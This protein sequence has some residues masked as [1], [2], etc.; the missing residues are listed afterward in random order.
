ML[1]AAGAY[2]VGLTAA[3][4][5][6]CTDTSAHKCPQVDTASRAQP[7]RALDGRGESV[8]IIRRR[9]VDRRAVHRSQGRNGSGPRDFNRGPEHVV[10]EAFDDPEVN[11]ADQPAHYLVERLG[12][13]G[14]ARQRAVAATEEHPL[15]AGLREPVRV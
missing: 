2:S 3:T 8:D 6:P 7:E 10:T 14:F 9:G 12:R 13:P 5:R 15:G 11:L 4:T 1:P